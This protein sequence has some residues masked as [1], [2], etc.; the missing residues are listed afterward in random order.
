MEVPKLQH[1]LLEL[2]GMAPFNLCSS[3]QLL[4][5]GLNGALPSHMVAHVK[6][7][8]H[9]AEDLL[10]NWVWPQYAATIPK[11]DFLAICAFAPVQKEVICL[12]SW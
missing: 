6:V 10:D 1:M 9:S 12:L 8:H 5:H 11:I 7:C 3:I 2:I 4:N